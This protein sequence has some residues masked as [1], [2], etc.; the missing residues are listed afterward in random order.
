MQHHTT[1]E[2]ASDLYGS[3]TRHNLLGI[4]VN[5]DAFPSGRLIA[6]KP[7]FI[8]RGEINRAVK[9]FGP[10]QMGSVVMWVRYHN[11]FEAAKRIYLVGR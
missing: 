8:F 3:D 9:Y 11:C 10:N 6:A 5:E 1:R 4:A 7:R 2:M